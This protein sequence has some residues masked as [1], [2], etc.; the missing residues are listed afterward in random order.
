MDARPSIPVR[1]VRDGAEVEDLCAG[2][3]PVA[4]LVSSPT[5]EPGAD[6]R[7]WVVGPPAEPTGILTAVRVR[8]GLVTASALLLDG[9]GDG[10]GDAATVAALGRLVRRSGATRLVG[11]A[12]HVGPVAERLAEARSTPLEMLARRQDA[13]LPG[14]WRDRGRVARP[15]DE[16]AL[17]DLYRRFEL[18]ALAADRLPAAVAGLIA[19]R[20]VV[21]AVDGDVVVG[22]QRI[23]ARSRRWDLWAGLSVPP[24]HRGRGLSRVVDA[25]AREVSRTAGRGT[26][27][28]RAPTNRV[29]HD[30]PGLVVHPW[31]EVRL[32]SPALRRRARRWAGRQARRVGVR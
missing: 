3:Q 24:E 22:A 23:E 10:D 15:A 13:P 25:W 27:G 7:C 2:H 9:D 11:G 14:D 5:N 8:P 31:A 20:R 26:A 28:V 17:V 21:V 18:E 4:V 29:P 12:D 6:A 32:P 30:V 1:R 16:P 19:Q